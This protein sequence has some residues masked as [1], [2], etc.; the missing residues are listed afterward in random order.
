[1]RLLDPCGI[2]HFRNAPPGHS[3]S[4]YFFPSFYSLF[5][6]L[7]LRFLTLVSV[8]NTQAISVLPGNASLS[9]DTFSFFPLTTL[10]GI[11]VATSEVCPTVSLFVAEECKVLRF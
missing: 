6:S 9:F 7:L 8:S 3:F 11:A 10:S 4:G 5:F 2:Y 1:M